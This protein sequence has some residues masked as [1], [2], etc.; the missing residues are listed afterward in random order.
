MKKRVSVLMV[1]IFMATAGLAFSA[2]TLTC[3]FS[4]GWKSKARQAICTGSKAAHTLGEFGVVLMVGGNIPDKTRVI[5]IAIYDHVEMLDYAVAHQLSLLLI[6]F[7]FSA[8]FMM[9]LFNR[10]WY[11]R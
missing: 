4:P 7:A 3:W 9:F 8:L 11:S 10:R 2:D 6:V 1:L 5:S